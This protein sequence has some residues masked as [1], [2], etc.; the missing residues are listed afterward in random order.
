MPPP[1]AA[2]PVVVAVA[3][4][5]LQVEGARQ[6][7]L[8]VRGAQAAGLRGRGDQRLHGHLRRL[9]DGRQPGAGQAVHGV[10]PGPVSGEAWG[11]E[12]ETVPPRLRPLLHV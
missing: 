1:A 2:V 3:V 11:G 8:V 9:A 10:A 7:R 4:R 6:H 12:V 5:A